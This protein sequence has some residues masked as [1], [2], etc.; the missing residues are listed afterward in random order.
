M[1]ICYQYVSY[2]G[3]HACMLQ[4]S[5]MENIPWWQLW[6]NPSLHILQTALSQK[7][8]LVHSTMPRNIIL[9]FYNNMPLKERRYFG[10][11]QV[12][13]RWLCFN[14]SICYQYS[15]LIANRLWTRRWSWSFP[16]WN[17]FQW[18]SNWCYLGWKSNLSWW[19]WNY[20]G[21]NLLWRVALRFSLCKN[22]AHSQWQWCLYCWCLSCRLYWEPLISEF[23]K[24]IIKMPVLSMPFRQLCT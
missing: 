12:T 14:G 7:V 20:Y 24:L 1:D 17:N 19:W 6:L 16:W 11:Q 18:C 2:T 23:F 9:K 8:H 3:T 4:K 5:Q 13:S 22:Q 10:F 15:W 21:Q